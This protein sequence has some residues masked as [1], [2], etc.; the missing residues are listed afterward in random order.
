MSPAK[1]QV[2]RWGA[3]VTRALTR[4]DNLA[5]PGVRV[6]NFHGVAPGDADAF[7]SLVESLGSR[8][9]FAGPADL[10]EPAA[11]RGRPVLLTFDDGV[12]SHS[13]VV[14]PVLE[15]L[16]VRAI[17]AV[18]SEF[19]SV[20]EHRQRAYAHEHRI[21]VD[22][23]VDGER[24]AMTWDEVRTLA[25]DHT[26]SCHTHTHHRF[27]ATDDL[28]VMCREVY[29]SKGE[30]ER[31]LG[32]NVD[33]FTWVGGEE[34]TYLPFALNHVQLAG[35]RRTLATNHLIA[36]RPTAEH[37]V[38]QRSHVEATFG[39]ALAR[40]QTGWAM[41]IRYLPKRRRIHRRLY[42]W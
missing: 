31:R 19:P 25:A 15:K 2:A 17:F 3:P 24:V 38:I 18:P 40:L 34:A 14:A 42:R 32:R 5:P 37:P 35:F 39:E 26:I 1:T 28:Q 11:V 22:S 10:L 36:R 13:S 29:E 33:T 21:Q 20:P 4:A 6:V 30:L 41:D 12:R 16:G 7:E 27:S 23:E 9:G 8:H